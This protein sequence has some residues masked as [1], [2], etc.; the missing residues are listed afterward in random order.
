MRQGSGSSDEYD[1]ESPPRS[2][3]V[4][5]MVER[6]KGAEEVDAQEVDTQDAVR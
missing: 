3:Y 2:T 6:I 5:S 4:V 1:R